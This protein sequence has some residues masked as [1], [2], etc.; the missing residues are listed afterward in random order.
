MCKCCLRVLVVVWMVG[1]SW[2]FCLSLK[3][4]FFVSCVCKVM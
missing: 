1:R 4:I 3:R 2:L